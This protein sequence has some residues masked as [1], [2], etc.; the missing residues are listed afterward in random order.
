[1][2][3]KKTKSRA[4]TK[5]KTNVANVLKDI[6]NLKNPIEKSEEKEEIK[7]EPEETQRENIENEQSRKGEKNNENQEVKKESKKETS[8]QTK[9]SKSDFEQ[10]LKKNDLYDNE[11]ITSM[12]VPSTLNK[13][14]KAIAHAAGISQLNFMINVLDTFI[15]EHQQEIK[16]LILKKN[17][18]LF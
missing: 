13:K 11:A 3:T 14:T 15:N 17:T 18:E 1:M 9:R 7:K 10:Y 8:E 12:A 5:P 6:H 2:T 16:K 4:N